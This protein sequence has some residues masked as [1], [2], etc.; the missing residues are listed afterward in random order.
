MWIYRRVLRISWRERR[1][2]DSILE[3]LDLQRELLNKI[4]ERKLNFVGHQLRLKQSELFIT[5]FQSAPQKR[6]RGRP[7]IGWKTDIQKWTGKN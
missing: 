3:E 2:N 1:T 4:K 6:N 5:I 7:R